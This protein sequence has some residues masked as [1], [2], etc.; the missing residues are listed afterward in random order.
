MND[1]EKQNILKRIEILGEALN[2][3]LEALFEIQAEYKLITYL[4]LEEKHG[5]ENSNLPS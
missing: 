2:T 4:L 1:I 5:N 3:A